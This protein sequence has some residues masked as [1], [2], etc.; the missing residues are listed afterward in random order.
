MWP[1]LDAGYWMLDSWCWILDAGCWLLREGFR[2]QMTEDRWQKADDEK[3]IV[4][5]YWL[6][7][8][9]SGKKRFQVSA[10]PLTEKRPV[11]SKKKLMN[12][13][14]RITPWRDP[15][16]NNVFYLFKKNRASLLDRSRDE[17]LQRIYFMKFCRVY[18]FKSIKRSVIHIRCSMLDVRC[19]MFTY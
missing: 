4:I 15:T 11:K 2:C 8:L 12:V 16:S 10:L 17:S 1:I 14:H 19:S 13:Q 9:V 18:I 3:V 7:V 6:L 5:C